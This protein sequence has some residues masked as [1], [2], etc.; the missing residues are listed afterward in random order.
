MGRGSSWDWPRENRGTG[1][2]VLRVMM[3]ERV[4]SMLRRNASK[5]RGLLVAGLVLLLCLQGMGCAGQTASQASGKIGVVDAQRVLDETEAGQRVKDRLSDFIKNRQT[6]IELEEKDLKRMEESIIKQA[7]VLSANARK[8]REEKFRR[9]MIQ[10]Q[11]KAQQI[12][13]E[14]QEEQ[15]EAFQGFRSEIEKVVSRVA[16]ELGLA[17]VIE[18]GEGGPTLY[19]DASVDIS[20]RVIEEFNKASK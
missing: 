20:G 12:N 16:L 1:L 7:S 6:L 18:S 11:Q 14:V 4:G 8:E 3:D 9:R 10:Y 19:S 17:V 2:Q 15:R 13:R 5:V